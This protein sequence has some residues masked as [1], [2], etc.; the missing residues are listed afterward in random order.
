MAEP[1]YKKVDNYFYD[2]A[3][4][5]GKGAFATVYQATDEKT[6]HKVAV[7][8]ISAVKLLESEDQYN[9]FMREI[10]VLREIKGEHIVRLLD[11]K[12]TTNNLYIFTDYCDGGDL[13][14]KLKAKHPFSEEEA[15][16]ILKQIADAFITI[17]NLHILN[18]KNHKVTI[19]HRDI[20]A[21]N[22]LFHEGK[23]RVA[24]F[25]FAKLIDEV[26]KN[27]RKAHT[28]L[29]T[30]L[31]MAPQILNDE[32]YSTKCDI[33]STGVL[34]YE[35]LFGKLPWTGHSVPNLYSNIKSKP[36]TFPKTISSETKDLITKMLKMKEDERLSWKEVYEHP[37]LKKINIKSE[38]KVQPQS[39]PVQNTQQQQQQQNQQLPQQQQQQTS[40][41][42]NSKVQTQAPIQKTRQNYISQ[43]RGTFASVDL[44]STKYDDDEP[45]DSD[46]PQTT[47]T[48]TEEHSFSDV[49]AAIKLTM[50]LKRKV[51]QSSSFNAQTFPMLVSLAVENL[52]S[53]NKAPL[54]LV[55]VIDKSGSMSGEKIE[56]VK[57]AFDYL[58]N[59]LGD[60]DRLSVILFN[61]GASRLFPLTRTTQAN[62]D[63]LLTQIQSIGAA[64]GTNINTGM[65]HA[66][67]TLKERKQANAVSSIFLL[68]DGLD[69]QAQHRVSA[70]LNEYGISDD[71]TI[72]TFGFGNDHDPQLMNDIADLR[73]GNF[74]FI[75]KLDTVDEA[76]VDCLGG[77]LSSVGQ[78]VLI[79]IKPEQ[80]EFLQGVEITKAYG[81]AIMWAREGDTYI[82]KIANL[83]SG[84]QKDYVL[85]L[86][87]PVNTKELL[88]EQKNIVVASAEADIV[89]LNNQHI[90]KKAELQITL[91]NEV[92]EVKEEEEDDREVMKNFYRVKGASVM[93]EARLLADGSKHEEAKK[94]LQSFKE[95]L[96]NSFLKTEEFIMNLV[97]DITQAIHNV[98]PTVYHQMGRHNMVENT[99]AQMTQKTNFKSAINYQNC[100][101]QEM[102]SH[103]R[104]M[105]SKK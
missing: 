4:P 56:L 101:Q 46:A 53:S 86:K 62:K 1:T 71:V 36:L 51:V 18:S 11:V 76:F 97:K 2:P 23:I 3:K 52:K 40:S 89:A 10:N 41:F 92:E 44:S 78:N 38:P 45:I 34:F 84:R 47:T 68:S 80:S 70:S 21:A 65:C 58:L 99:R 12:R 60:S 66:F 14:K 54:D 37:A 88:D 63:R 67:K 55:C 81:D 20:K 28:L 90:V 27:T 73:D 93:S 24:D 61:S 13:E 31:Y 49:E 19:M 72:S 25:G 100:V 95:E 64:G 59:Y 50:R 32:N 105:K 82:T 17:E 94:I 35:V 15:C 16:S 75:E 104:A 29:G 26:D 74:Y 8:V 5:L 42:S 87:V 48:T 85:E 103:V 102:T 30:P 22:I 91:L 79:K 33:W 69:G 7:K 98:E 9:L 83:I 39:N 77:L 6:N 43:Q 96:E 57:Q